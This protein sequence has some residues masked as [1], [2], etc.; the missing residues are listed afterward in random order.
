MSCEFLESPYMRN[1]TDASARQIDA[2]REHVGD[3]LRDRRVF[4]LRGVVVREMDLQTPQLNP[5][6][7]YEKR[8]TKDAARLR[9]YNRVLEAV[10][11]RIRTIS[12]L[13]QGTTHLL[14]QVPPFIYGVPRL[15]LEDL[16]VYLIHQLRHSNFHVRYSYPNLLLID[17]SHHEKTYLT[18]QSPVMQ[19]MMDSV[20]RTQAEIER[21]EREA[22]RLLAPRKGA[23]K[24][25]IQ[26]PG[27]NQIRAI[28]P[29]ALPMGPSRDAMNVVLGRMPAAAPSATAA[30]SAGSAPSAAS[31]T[32]S[33][34]FLQSLA[35]P[36]AQKPRA[37]ADYFK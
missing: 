33:A 22:S 14:Y 30:P 20:E 21:R 27:V 26:E 28:P 37:M 35:N 32:P 3:A 12:R 7:L 15:D 18:E 4:F 1:A 11:H 36:G 24:V 10:Y 9:V 23:R 2:T 29:T 19:A 6:E 16:C 34:T 31:Y 13:P 25:R 5:A 17:W 8:R